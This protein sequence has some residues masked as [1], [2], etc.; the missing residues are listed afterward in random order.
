DEAG[1]GLAP[2]LGIRQDGA[3][4]GGTF[5][6]HVGLPRLALRALGAVLR[7]ALATLGDAGGIQRTADGVVTH[8]RQVL[9][10]AAADQHHGVL[11]EVVAFA[12]DV[13][14]D[15]VAV[16]QAHLGDLTQGR[17]RLLRGGGVGAGAGTAALRARLQGRRGALVRFRLPRL[18]DQLVDRRHSKVLLLGAP[19]TGAGRENDGR[20]KDGLPRHE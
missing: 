17:V 5:T 9:D 20:P 6:G 2:V 13:R 12:A 8:A 4:G 14:A 16:G 3:L 11:L 10:A 19:R 1:D 7:T 18:A 15:L